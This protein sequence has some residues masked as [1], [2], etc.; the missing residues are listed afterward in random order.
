MPLPALFALVPLCA[1]AL[2]PAPADERVVHTSRP[3]PRAL[4]LPTEEASF[5]F[6]V[7]G[8]R[9]GGPAE[10][11]SVLAEAVEEV[12]W[13]G[14]DLVLTV[15]DLIQGYNADAEWLAE[16]R[17]FRGIMDRLSMPW[18][19]VAGN[20]DVYYRGEGRTP[21]EHEP[22][23]ELHFGPL[24]YA[25]EHQRCWFVVLYSDE[26]NPETGERN[27]N[28]PEC[29]RL[30]PEQFQWLDG[31]LTRAA[32]AEHVFLFLHHP[33]WTL[34]QY[35]DDWEKVHRRLVQAG[36]V[37]AVF[38][39]HI[40]QMRY[41]PRDGIE[42]FALATVGGDQTAL[43]PQAGFLHQ[44]HL[45]TV[46]ERGLSVVAYPVGQALDPRSI[47]GQVNRDVT[48]LSGG[49]QP[50]FEALPALDSEGGGGGRLVLWLRNPSSSPVEVELRLLCDDLDWWFDVDHAH[51]VLEPGAEQRFDLA[52]RRYA[53]GFGRNLRLP[54]LELGADLLAE[55]ARFPLPRR[56]FD[57]PF[58]VELP[59]PPP[60]PDEQV[61]ALDGSQYAQ[62]PADR[63][64]LSD[65]PF[66]LE[67]WVRA[68]RF[69]A[70]QGLVA[71]TESSEYG[72]FADDGEPRFSVHLAGRYVTVGAGEQRLIPGRW[73]HLAG[74]FDGA[75]VRLYLD[76]TCVGRTAAQGSRRTNQLP[77]ILGG[78]VRGDGTGDSLLVGE[79]DEVRVSET[80]RYGDESFVPERRL[81]ADEQTVLL[82]HCDAAVG[83]WLF[84]SSPDRAHATLVGGARVAGP[85]P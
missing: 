70:R 31:I 38:G 78:D 81:S 55:T 64:V 51:G 30:S 44:Y 75:E 26:P 48:L 15:G 71:K 79:L 85:R 52:A 42:Y 17:E 2:A 3:N 63:A 65:G 21:L 18:F 35:G 84:D 6:V 22:N 47:T 49:L 1:P 50:R 5:Q 66:T 16:M 77:L 72:L 19:P 32:Q 73:H 28:R 39:G 14:P 23:Y 83:P 82:L 13:L 57:L 11:V 76:G 20:H 56:E 10:G 59:E 46:R 4:P 29:Q 43:A 24:W 80:A 7:F 54:R 33:R 53:T 27:F 12:N 62:V 74:V 41:D 36:N 8:D 45:V 68:E 37:S 67:F 25:F 40:H 58:P 69:A 9:T 61:L 34:G 60:A